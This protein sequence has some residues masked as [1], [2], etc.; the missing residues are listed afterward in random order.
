MELSI[1][2]KYESNRKE[3]FKQKKLKQLMYSKKVLFYTKDKAFSLEDVN[4]YK[5]KTKGAFYIYLHL[6]KKMIY[7]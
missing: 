2:E 5:E 4:R 6:L 1:L 7:P 3:I